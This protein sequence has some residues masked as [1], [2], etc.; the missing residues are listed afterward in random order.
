MAFGPDAGLTIADRI[1]DDPAM[2]HY[3]FLP[4]VRADFLAKLGRY[5]EA[6]SEAERAAALTDNA[7][8][9]AMFLERAEQYG[10]ANQAK[11]RPKA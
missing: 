3:P 7:R 1:R 4:S 11:A 10:R 5:P 9:K 8:Q 2:A 6:Q